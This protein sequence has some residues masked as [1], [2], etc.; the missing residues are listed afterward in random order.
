MPKNEELIKDIETEANAKG[1]DIPV[2]E[3]LSNAQLA[4]T[5]KGLKAAAPAPT[6]ETDGKADD[7]K[8]DDAADDSTDDDEVEVEAKA[9]YEMAPGKAL[10]TL[11]GC[12]GPGE[13][14]KAEY[15]IDGKDGL[16]RH[17]K[18]GLVVKN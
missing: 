16:K 2:T 8:A 5:L 6:N 4:E 10:T 12:I 17:V 9:P 11:K 15:L 3:G 7:G 14:I 13:E 1:V 18:N